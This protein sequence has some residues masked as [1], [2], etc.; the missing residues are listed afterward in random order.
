[1]RFR[2]QWAHIPLHH[3]LKRT[4]EGSVTIHAI[5]VAKV[6]TRR[7]FLSSTSRSNTKQ[8]VMRVMLQ[9]ADRI[10]G[11]T[12]TGVERRSDQSTRDLGCSFRGC[13]GSAAWWI[14]ANGSVAVHFANPAT[15][16]K[17]HVQNMSSGICASSVFPRFSSFG[18]QICKNR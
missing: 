5:G 7:G 10:R 16:A 13:Q 18:R 4:P 17:K 15:Y 8:N 11:L 14:W 9:W 3:N 1:M 12:L 2:L 6:L